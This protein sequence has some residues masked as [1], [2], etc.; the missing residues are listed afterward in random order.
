MQIVFGQAAQL[1]KGIGAFDSGLTSSLG[2][3][4]GIVPPPA[5]LIEPVPVKISMS[6]SLKCSWFLKKSGMN[7]AII[8]TN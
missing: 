2:G 8:I 5:P 3:F 6:L 4:G 1:G 7:S